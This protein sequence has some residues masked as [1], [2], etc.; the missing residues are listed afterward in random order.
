MA[1]LA[2]LITRLT[3]EETSGTCDA[4]AMT[5]QQVLLK[6]LTDNKASKKFIVTCALGGQA[7]LGAKLLIDYGYPNVFVISNGDKGWEDAGCPLVKQRNS[8]LDF[9]GEQFCPVET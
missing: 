8:R 7:M 2:S 4:Q 6:M 9:A 3:V 1:S 5:Q